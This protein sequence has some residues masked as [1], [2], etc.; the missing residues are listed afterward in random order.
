VR[1]ALRRSAATFRRRWGEQVSEEIVI[2]AAFLILAIP[3][4]S[5]RPTSTR[6]SSGTSRRSGSA[7]APAVSSA[8]TPAVDLG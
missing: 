4:R 3:H 5:P 1:D 2:G 8:A 7:A 6:G